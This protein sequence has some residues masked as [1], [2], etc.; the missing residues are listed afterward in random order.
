MT[1]FPREVFA[2]IIDFLRIRP[3]PKHCMDTIAE[4]KSMCRARG[5]RVGGN[6]TALIV[7]LLNHGCAAKRA[8]WNSQDHATV[9]NTDKLPSNPML[10]FREVLHTREAWQA[11]AAS[12]FDVLDAVCPG[13]QELYDRFPAIDRWATSVVAPHRDNILQGDLESVLLE[14]LPMCL[15]ASKKYEKFFRSMNGDDQR[16]RPTHRTLAHDRFLKI[17]GNELRSQVIRPH[18]M[19]RYAQFVCLN[20]RWY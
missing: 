20:R 2:N 12:V 11:H 7:R 19:L 17:Y 13:L 6:K 10:T 18:T 9:W 16:A 8:F 14:K 4:L 3:N 5:L 15:E 1:F